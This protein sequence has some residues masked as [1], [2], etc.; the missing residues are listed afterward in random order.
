[1][2]KI[3][4]FA[5]TTIFFF[6]CTASFAQDAYITATV[7]VKKSGEIMDVATQELYNIDTYTEA[8]KNHPNVK[9]FFNCLNNYRG[10]LKITAKNNGYDPVQHY[11]QNLEVDK[12]ST[13][14]RL[15]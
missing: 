8:D 6:T 15:K 14:Q 12:K 2:K 10:K 3:I 13:C 11:T 4:L 9:N 7:L 1:M 5:I